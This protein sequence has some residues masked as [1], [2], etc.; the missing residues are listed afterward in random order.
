[1]DRDDGDPRPEASGQG[2]WPLGFAGAAAVAGA[3]FPAGLMT[4]AGD[5]CNGALAIPMMPSSWDADATE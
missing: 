5:G 2:G 1:M 4:L 3:C